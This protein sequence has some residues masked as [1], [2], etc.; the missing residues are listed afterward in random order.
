MAN[1]FS[2]A[3]K[4]PIKAAKPADKKVRVSVNDDSFFDKSF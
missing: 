3:R 2:K 4:T 1:L